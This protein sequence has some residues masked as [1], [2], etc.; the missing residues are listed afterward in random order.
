MKTETADANKEQEQSEQPAVGAAE[1]FVEPE[2]VEIVVE[3]A[4]DQLV[5]MH[6]RAG[7]SLNVTV[8]MG[9]DGAVKLADELTS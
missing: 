2:Q 3:D 1:I 9:Q 6:V 8:F 7:R 4:D 5:K